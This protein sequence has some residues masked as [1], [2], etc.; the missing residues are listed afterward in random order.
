MALL[1]RSDQSHA[2][3]Y[4]RMNVPTSRVGVKKGTTG[5]AYARANL[6]RAKI[7]VFE[8]VGQGK[9]ALR[10]ARSTTS[11]TTPRRSGGRPVDSTTTP[12]WS[13]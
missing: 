4:A 6:P 8:T 3:D 2:T 11:S 1:R 10:K 9:A 13:G 12:T 7:V 5:E